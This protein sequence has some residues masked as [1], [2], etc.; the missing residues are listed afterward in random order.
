MKLVTG[1]EYVTRDGSIGTLITIG[2]WGRLEFAEPKYSPPF[3]FK[4]ED[5]GNLVN[6]LSLGEH[7]LD[8]ISEV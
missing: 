7:P 1:K 5:R 3:D 6:P 8:I 4:D 2:K